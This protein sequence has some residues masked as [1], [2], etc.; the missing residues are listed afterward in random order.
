MNKGFRFYSICL[1][2]ALPFY[3]LAQDQVN[4]VASADA[5]QVVLGGYFEVEF[6]LFDAEGE[7]FNPPNLK[8]DFNIISGPGESRRISIVNG[9]RSQSYGIS[10]SLQPKEIGKFTIGAASI[11][12]NG[13][14]YRTKPI[15]VE[16]VKGRNSAAATQEELNEELGDGVFIKAIL[17]KEASKI[18]EQI[19]LDYKLYTSR[20]IDSYNV[21]YESE[22]PGFFVHEVRRFNGRQIQEVIEGVQYTT[23]VIKRVALFPQ[24]AGSFDIEPLQMNISIA[25]G[26]RERRSIFSVP[27][28]S[29]FGIKTDSINIQVNSLPSPMPTSFTGAVGKFEMRTS[30]NRNKLTT[31]D[32]IT[33][34]MYVNGNGDIKQVQ[35]PK[36]ALSDNFE[37]YDPKTLEEN[38]F[39]SGGQLN[40]KKVFEYLI[41]PKNPGRD[42]ITTA[43]TYY[44]SDS[45]K[46]ITLRS[47][48]FPLWIQKGELDRTQVIANT[49]KKT[50][51]RDIQG[52]QSDAKFYTCIDCFIGSRPFWVLLVLPFLVLGGVIVQRQIEISKGNIDRSELKRKL[53]VKVAQK[54]LAQADAFMTSGNS[55]SFYD[56]VSRASFGYVCDKLNIPYSELT[57][58][59]VSTKM[60]SLAVSEQSIDKFMQIVKTCEMALFAGKDNTAAMK[61]TYQQAIE[62]IA[63]I[64]EQISN[65]S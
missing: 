18:G 60:Q 58:Q 15:S 23:K 35:A 28:V 1:L 32:A 8:K 7:N 14:T 19:I 26:G 27:K 53:A 10:Y 57:K 2:L 41:L 44:N 62:V 61:E 20:N 36:L 9:A 49:N 3:V 25:V 55:R 63:E 31:D 40:G 43:F 22:Y 11:Q 46:Y 52:L 54:R 34:R 50:Q 17:N 59:N 47:E 12:V 45:L 48:S 5:R 29:T 33:L 56:E 21:S 16:V 42:T 37:V 4:F 13:K 30:I 38:S 64:E 39:E 6:T 65:A 24:Q 51:K